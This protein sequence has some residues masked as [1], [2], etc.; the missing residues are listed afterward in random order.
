MMH[1]NYFAEFSHV[2]FNTMALDLQRTNPSQQGETAG[3]PQLVSAQ[4]SATG[5]LVRLHLP[6]H[7]YVKWTQNAAISLLQLALVIT[8]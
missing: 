8:L 7:F 4:H 6:K 5:M 1:R 3:S 2:I